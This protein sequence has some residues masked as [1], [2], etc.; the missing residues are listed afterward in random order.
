M[1]KKTKEYKRIIFTQEVI[2]EAENELVS[3][4]DKNDRKL[5]FTDYDISI[6]DI[7]TWEHDS[8]SEFFADYQKPFH[9]AVYLK[10][11]SYKG[12]LRLSIYYN[13]TKIEIYLPTRDS[14]ESVFNIFEKNVESQS[15][16]MKKRR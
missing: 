9:R 7:E 6:S 11:Y 8:E 5:V 15:N 2:K 1:P 4:L 3:C 10:N 12:Y 16:L 14:V 13:D